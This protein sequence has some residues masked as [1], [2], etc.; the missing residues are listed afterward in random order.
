MPRS[1]DP[2]SRNTKITNFILAKA[3]KDLKVVNL[4]FRA[5]VEIKN[6]ARGTTDPGITFFV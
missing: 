3:K 6:I 1:M 4:Q 5:N 2:D